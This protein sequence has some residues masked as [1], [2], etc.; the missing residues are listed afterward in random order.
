[1]KN[2]KNHIIEVTMPER[3]RHKKVRRGQGETH[4]S[5]GNN[6]KNRPEE[7]YNKKKKK[8]KKNK[9]KSGKEKGTQRKYT[10]MVEG[11][12]TRS[13]AWAKYWMPLWYKRSTAAG[14]L[15]RRGNWCRMGGGESLKET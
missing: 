15:G 7:K 4:T 8:Q 12:R 6:P 1:M 11:A 2:N 10:R 13:G 5:N 9:T 3:K 14:G